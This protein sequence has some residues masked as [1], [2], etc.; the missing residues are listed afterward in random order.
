[1]D[2]EQ[3]RLKYCGFM[4]E[5]KTRLNS[6]Y[7]MMSDNSGKIPSV[8][9]L[10]S[11]YLQLRMIS[12]L[13]SIASLSAHGDLVIGLTKS[14]RKEYAANK[15]IEAAEL[16][17]PR[18]YPQPGRQ[19]IGNDGR[20]VEVKKVKEGFLGKAE[21]KKLYFECGDYLHRGR[22][23]NVLEEKTKTLDEDRILHWCKLI[24]NL[25]DHHQIQTLDAD[26][27]YFVV[28]NAG[29]QGNVQLAVMKKLSSK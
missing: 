21:L 8:I 26:L 9:M 14:L 12:E 23:G 13:I 20:V 2:S 22:L 5:I 29:E 28:M 25:L 10:E 4:S 16:L 27:M 6:I 7:D 1:M 11:C 18:F 19:I 15:I 24:V 17:H 3:F